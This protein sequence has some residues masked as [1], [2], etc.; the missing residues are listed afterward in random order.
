MT[1]L[2]ATGDCEISTPCPCGSACTAGTHAHTR[3]SR[4]AMTSRRC[5]ALQSLSVVCSVREV[6]APLRPCSLPRPPR[7][8]QASG[9]P[10]D[11]AHEDGARGPYIAARYEPVV[12]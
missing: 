11:P 3:A 12:G 4:L 10:H 8:R 6:R 1:W 2:M 5:M 7:D 9:A